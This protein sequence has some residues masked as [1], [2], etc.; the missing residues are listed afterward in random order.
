ML[1]L[2]QRIK[3]HKPHFYQQYSLYYGIIGKRHH[4]RNDKNQP[5]RLE[6]IQPIIYFHLINFMQMNNNSYLIIKIQ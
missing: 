1:A 4:Q 5:H 2:Q 3:N 6:D